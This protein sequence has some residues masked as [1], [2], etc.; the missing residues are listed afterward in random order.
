MM[1]K[2]SQ[3]IYDTLIRIMPELQ[4]RLQSHASYVDP[5]AAKSLFSIWKSGH[6]VGDREYRKPVTMG[7]EEI[8]RMKDA[9]LVNQI[10][11]KLSVTNKGEKVIRV[12]VLGDDRSVFEDSEIVI[13]YNQALSSTRGVK[14]ARSMKAAQKEPGWWDRFEDNSSME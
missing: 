2:T 13:D 12:M 9:G 4:D 8:R 6:K 1:R 3:S 7:H 5:I 11:D 10:G 14:T